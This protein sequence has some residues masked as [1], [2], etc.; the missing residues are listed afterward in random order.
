MV[1]GG[2]GVE[3]RCMHMRIFGFFR[4]YFVGE[5]LSGSDSGHRGRAFAFDPPWR[6]QVPSNGSGYHREV[7][8]RQAIIL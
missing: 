7:N 8:S 5:E 4:I 6:I 1:G 2:G 3:F